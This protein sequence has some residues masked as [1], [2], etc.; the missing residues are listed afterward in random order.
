MASSLTSSCGIFKLV[1]LSST[2]SESRSLRGISL[3][4]EPA[5][6]I[7]GLYLSRI[8]LMGGVSLCL[9]SSA[10]FSVISS[11]MLFFVLVGDSA[12]S[13]NVSRASMS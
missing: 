9:S 12:R 2:A 8:L 7:I 10:Y 6:S 11:R 4:E 1:L 13:T 5:P 3:E